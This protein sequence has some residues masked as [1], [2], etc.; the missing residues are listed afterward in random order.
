ML[1][2]ALWFVSGILFLS[3]FTSIAMAETSPFAA[4]ADPLHPELTFR[5]AYSAEYSGPVTPSLTELVRVRS[6]AQAAGLAMPTL[7]KS[8]RLMIDPQ[9]RVLV[10]IIASD[11]AAMLP[12]LNALGYVEIGSRADLLRTE[13]YLPINMVESVAALQNPGIRSIAPIRRPILHVGRVTSQADII[14][15]A[16]RVRASVPTGFDGTGI[17][18]GVLSDSY[19]GTG[20]AAAGVLGGD[21]PPNVQVLEDYLQSDA[22]DEGRGMLELIHDLAPGSGLAFA[23]AYGGEIGFALNITR[24]QQQAGCKVIVDD[25]GYFE[26]PMFQ[27][28]VVAQAVDTVRAAGTAYF[29][30]AGNSG[31]SSYESIAYSETTI[32]TAVDGF[33]DQWFNFGTPGLP[34]ATQ[35]ITFPRFTEMLISFQWD[36][37]FD[38]AAPGVQTNLDI[39]FVDTN[40]GEIISSSTD[41][42]ISTNRPVELGY[43]VNF[44]PGTE[45]AELMIHRKA[46]PMPTRIK[47]IDFAGGVSV[48]HATNSSTISGHPGAAGAMGVAA[49]AY[50]DHYRAESFSSRGPVTMLFAPNGT[51]LP[52]AT[53]REKPDIMAIDGTDTSFFPGYQGADFEGNGF[54]NFFGTSAAAP[55]AAAIAALMLS[56]N[57]A[58]TPTQIYD[59]MRSTADSRVGTPGYDVAT[60]Y[61]LVNDYAAVFGPPVPATLPFLDGFESGVLSQAW[62]TVTNVNGRIRVS[63]SNAPANGSYHAMLDTFFG[64]SSPDSTSRNELILHINPAG[65]G[66]VT[67]SFNQKEFTDEDNIMSASFNGQQDS[68]GVAFSADGNNW[69]RLVSLTSA[70]SLNSYQPFTFNLSSIAASN[71]VTLGSD[72]RIKFQQFDNSSIPNDGFAFDDIFIVSASS[73]PFIS[74]QSHSV[75]KCSGEMVNLTVSAISVAAPSYRWRKNGI[76]LVDGGNVSGSSTPSLSLNSLSTSDIGVYSVRVT[77]PNGFVDSADISIGVVI[78]PFALI[79]SPSELRCIGDSILFAPAVGGTAPLSFQWYKDNNAIA[80]RTDPTL[81]LAALTATDTGSYTLAVTNPC[82]TFTS[83]P[84]N[85]TVAPP[86]TCNPTLG[87]QGCPD[88]QTVTATSADG[89][90]VYFYP[91]QV[92][93]ASNRVLLASTHAPATMFPVGETTVTFSATDTQTAAFESCSFKVTVINTLSANGQPTFPNITNPNAISPANP[94]GQSTPTASNATCASVGL[95]DGMLVAAVP[96]A[97]TFVSRRSRR[98]RLSSLP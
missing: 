49:A 15:Q 56:R 89:A 87:F 32:Q 5:T 36:D 86:I 37:P 51:R 26:E 97:L 34:D 18:V 74:Q 95:V 85:F 83:E 54:P 91:P 84:I 1:A 50:F 33:T 6:A 69:I 13:G 55:H 73:P 76:D 23:T 80:G 21:L 92:I 3:S 31:T 28:G 79:T 22:T 60:G 52:Q 20:T 46:G 68:D 64:A 19:N 72:V 38:S 59:T 43:L 88:D 40:T 67:L 98:R 62:E 41:N 66:D 78:A 29:S 14:M 39:Y 61:G 96:I 81:A 8:V 24:L 65:A 63:A 75:V 57:S 48:E 4:P 17:K 7:P 90:L 35:H 10:R 45:T 16:D 77:N 25:V 70:N 42:N 30:S 82:R 47:W 44:S 11:I 12:R 93:P 2:R 53:S 71:G 27:D 9:E 94:L 58:L